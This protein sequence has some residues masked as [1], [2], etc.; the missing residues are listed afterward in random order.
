MPLSHHSHSSCNRYLCDVSNWNHIFSSCLVLPFRSYLWP[1]FFI[2][3]FQWI[4][5]FYWLILWSNS[6]KHPLVL[7]NPV[8]TSF[9]GPNH[10]MDHCNSIPTNLLAY[11]LLPP[12]DHAQSITL[13]NKTLFSFY[14][15]LKSLHFPLSIILSLRKSPRYSKA[16]EFLSVYL[17][18]YFSTQIFLELQKLGEWY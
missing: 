18:K 6:Q 10:L 2:I 12:E 5:T 11:A 13:S 9:Q 1:L 7:I 16:F 14:Y 17:S 15:L 3:Q 4:I 8:T